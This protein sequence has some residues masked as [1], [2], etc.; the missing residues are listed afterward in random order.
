MRSHGNVQK[1]ESSN[2]VQRRLIDGFH[3]QA[4]DYVRQVNPACI[5][6]VGC[7]EGYVLAHLQRAGIDA[8]LIGVDLS[9]AA[10]EAARRRVASPAELYVGDARTIV[11]SRP[12]RQ[13]DLVMMLEVLE[14]LEDPESMLEDLSTLTTEHV[15]LSVPREPL[16]RTMNLL[17][18]KNVR[19]LG[20]DPEHINHWSARAFVGMVSRHFDVVATARPF[21]W[22]MVLAHVHRTSDARRTSP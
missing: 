16:F 1:H 19:D 14:H 11:S 21:P 15:L 8:D 18:L 6:E 13:P 9:E 7:G 17:R 4:V 12:R 20:N 10:I 5:L 3:R 2:P 22:T